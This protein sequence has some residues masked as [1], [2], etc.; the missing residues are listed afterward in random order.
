MIV[1]LIGPSGVGKSAATRWLG[2]RLPN[3]RV[4]DLDQSCKDREGE[5]SAVSAELREAERLAETEQVVVNIGAGTQHLLPTRLI[6]VLSGSRGFVVLIQALAE[7]VFYRQPQ[8]P[9]RRYEEFVE[10]EYTKRAPLYAI[11]GQTVDVSG[12]DCAPAVRAVGEAVVALLDRDF[13]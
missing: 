1:Y 4:F 8:G 13:S 11:A 7:E 2:S 9:T 5:W 10:T 12:M 3:L 6:D